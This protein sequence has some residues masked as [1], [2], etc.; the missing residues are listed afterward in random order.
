MLKWCLMADNVWYINAD[1]INTAAIIDCEKGF[2]WVYIRGLK[3]ITNPTWNTCHLLRE[4]IVFKFVN[5]QT[6]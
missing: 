4:K 1:F 6:D 2:N 5:K 3:W